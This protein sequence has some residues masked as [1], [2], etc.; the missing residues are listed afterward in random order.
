LRI[1][2]ETPEPFT[3]FSAADLF[4]CTS[5][6]ESFPRVIL[7]AMSF[8]LP[9]VT[10]PVFGISEQVQENVN[11]L[12]YP[13]GDAKSLATKLTTL[14][15]DSSFRIS[16]GANSILVLQGLTDFEQMTTAYGEIFREAW[17]TQRGRSCAASSA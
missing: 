8:G 3:Y 2:P 6:I 12:L 16:L 5:R 11:A 4:V 15:L 17:L 10:T 13:P 7:E 14:V 9:I 1:L